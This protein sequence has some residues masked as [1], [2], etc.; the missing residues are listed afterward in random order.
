MKRFLKNIPMPVTGLMLS[1][2]ALGNLIQSYGNSYRNILG[3]VATFIFVLV[4]IKILSD[5]SNLLEI[6]A[7]P[8]GASV[9]TTYTMSIMLLATYV[10]PYS[11]G[12]ALGIWG[13][14][15]VLHIVL[16]LYFTMKF[17]KN[18]N[19]MQVFPSWFI[20]YVGIAVASVT[21]KAFYAGIGQWAF[22]FAFISYLILIPVVV[23]RVFFVK[24]MPEPT[25]P[26]LIIF[27]APGSLCLA[28][29]LNSFDHKNM[30]LFGFLLV[31]SQAIYLFA[32]IK[33]TGLLRLKF[34]PT[35]SGFTFPLVISAIALK[36]SN[37][38]LHSQGYSWRLLSGLVKIE[39]V[40]AVCIV[41][42]VFIRY[43]GHMVKVSR[44]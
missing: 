24:Q 4:T 22:I 15:I 41:F 10:K 35:Y 31:L 21:G 25:L 13:L 18:F 7:N 9:F 20:V 34:Y 36:G 5:F 38:F 42:Y 39:E 30:I 19:I 33:L 32:I 12:I 28:G 23:K 3:I 14:G 44:S 8:L 17:V 16:I 6:L 43:V 37:V 27:A 40:I 2:A 1:F 29:Y 11:A 26:T